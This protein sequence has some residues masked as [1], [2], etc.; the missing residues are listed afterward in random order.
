MT[1]KDVWRW[2]LPK[3]DSDIIYNIYGKKVVCKGFRTTVR[4]INLN[5][6]RFISNLLDKNNFKELVLWA[7]KNLPA[8]LE[9]ITLVDKEVN[10]LVD[11][12]TEKGVVDVLIKL[13]CE[14]QERKAVQFFAFLQDEQSHLL[15][16][17]N[18]SIRTSTTE[19]ATTD[20]PPST[21]KENEVIEIN[22]QPQEVETIK[23]D[24]KKM[25]KLEKKVENLNEELK[26]RDSVH[27]AKMDELERNHH[28]TIQKLN[29]KNQLYGNLVKEKNSLEK[30]Y[31]EEKSKWEKE[32][33]HYKSTIERL[34]GEV[35]KLQEK[36]DNVSNDEVSKD[37]ERGKKKAQ[38]LVIGKPHNTTHFQSETIE[39]SFVE[40][41]D[42]HDFLFPESLD[43]YWVLSYEL[44][45]KEQLLLKQNDSYSKLNSNKVIIC[46]NFIEVRKQMNYFNGR[47]ERIISHVRR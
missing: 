2:I 40:G 5:R 41:N 38:I 22:E 11:I 42:V 37:D 15:D 36:L 28:Q 9:G 24:G 17:P 19:A 3:F 32:V 44:L 13:L 10:E 26:K 25:K 39:F 6:N 12:A 18:Q 1:G 33:S 7:A 31:K 20:A 29:E 4:D 27:K 35:S 21:E 23:F 46:K 8:S 43:A 34:E 30:Q 47:E 45:N 16:I 14:N